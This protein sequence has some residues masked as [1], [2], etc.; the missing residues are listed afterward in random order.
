MRMLWM[1]LALVP[2]ATLAGIDT[3]MHEKSRRV[4]KVEQVLHA[5]AGVLLIA[6]V[7]CV[8]SGRNSAGI[9][10][11]VAFAFVAF[12]DEFGFHR[13]L[14]SRERMVHF[15]SYGALAIFVTAWRL[16]GVWA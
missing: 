1:A 7:V 14:S 5:L 13:H 12:A 2:Y 9:V 8:F 10:A 16:N 11:F 4:P 3:W 15:A 6:F